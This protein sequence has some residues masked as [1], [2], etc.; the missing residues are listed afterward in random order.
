[1]PTVGM[2][3]LSITGE[4]QEK[5]TGKDWSP[6]TLCQELQGIQNGY[7]EEQEETSEEERLDLRLGQC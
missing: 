3:L 1:M 7:S 2:T 4:A 5:C 6:L